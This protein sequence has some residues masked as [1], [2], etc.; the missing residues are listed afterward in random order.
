[1]LLHNGN[2]LLS[3]PVAHFVGLKE[4]LVKVLNKDGSGFVYLQSI[5][6]QLMYAKFKEGIFIKPQNSKVIEDEMFE[7]G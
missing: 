5:F 3:I 2:K 4:N 7:K 6:P 1:M